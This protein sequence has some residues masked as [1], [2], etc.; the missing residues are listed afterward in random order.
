MKARSTLFAAAVLGAL[1]AAAPA[2]AAAPAPAARPAQADV[3]AQDREYL[4]RTH[5]NNLYEIVTGTLAERGGC[6]RV[7]ELGPRFAEH[8]TALDADLI[9]VATGTGVMLYS[10]PDN[11]QLTQIADLAARSGRDFDTAWLRDQVAAHLRATALGEWETRYGWSSAVKALA[12]RSEPV[13]RHHL[14]ETLAAIEACA[15]T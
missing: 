10:V 3:S 11:D 15:A 7:R 5:Q 6:A 2:A 1:L 12:A 14:D 4:N 13:L 8:H 9:A